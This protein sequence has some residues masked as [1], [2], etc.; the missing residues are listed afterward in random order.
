MGCEQCDEYECDVSGVAAFNQ[1][2]GNWT[3]S[4]VTDMSGMFKNAVAFNMSKY[5]GSCDCEQCNGYEW[6]V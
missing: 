2:I 1:N 4:S 6:D 5:L 3:V